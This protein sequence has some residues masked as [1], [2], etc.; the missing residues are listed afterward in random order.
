ML[1]LQPFVELP[2]FG[3][4]LTRSLTVLRLLQGPISTRQLVYYVLQF[5]TFMVAVVMKRY[6]C[7]S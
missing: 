4:S 6:P 1:S 2:L 3:A 5:A 7:I